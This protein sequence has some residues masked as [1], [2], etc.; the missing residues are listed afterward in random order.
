MGTIYLKLEKEKITPELISKVN[1]TNC[2]RDELLELFEIEGA[3]K[4]VFSTDL[5][6]FTQEHLCAQLY[7]TRYLTRDDCIDILNNSSRVH[8]SILNRQTD[9]DIETL[10]KNVHKLNL[11]FIEEQENITPEFANMYGEKMDWNRFMRYVRERGDEERFQHC[12]PNIKNN[13]DSIIHYS[14]T[15]EEQIQILMNLG[16]VSKSAEIDV[17]INDIYSTV[18]SAVALTK[19]YYEVN[20]TGNAR[21][22]TND[23]IRHFNRNHDRDAVY[24]WDEFMETRDCALKS[25]YW[26]EF[27]K[28]RIISIISDQ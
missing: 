26:D 20:A 6:E 27:F 4:I 11:Y 10:T 24:T 22:S 5:S 9:I 1:L 14:N 19:V 21:N 16:G 17:L 13:L 15:R 25:A 8:N 28:D 23:I 12:K 18:I 2:S 3:R 7:N